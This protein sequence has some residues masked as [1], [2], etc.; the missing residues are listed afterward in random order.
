V[1]GVFLVGVCS[2]IFFVF[3]TYPQLDKPSVYAGC[4]IADRLF[5]A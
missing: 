1:G 3:R 4:T 2:L 5:L